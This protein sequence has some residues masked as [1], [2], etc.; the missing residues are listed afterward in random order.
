MPFTVDPVVCPTVQESSAGKVHHEEY[1][2]AHADLTHSIV[3]EL[4][5]LPW[6]PPACAGD[7]SDSARCPERDQAL[8][9]RQQLNQKQVTCVI[10]AFG[11]PGSL[12]APT[13]HWYEPPRLQSDGFPTPVGTSFSVLAL[14]SQL[15]VV[16]R[17]PYV[18]S[19]RPALGEATRIGVPA[20]PVPV[21]CPRANDAP[22]PKLVDAMD[23]EGLGRQPVV[24]ELRK[25]MLPAL[26]SCADGVDFCD[27]LH[28]SG[29]E[30]TIVARRALTCVRT[31][32]D[33]KLSGPAPEVAYSQA[34]GVPAG[35][36]VPPFGD[37][38]HAT[39][40]FGLALTWEEAN[41]VAKHPGVERLWTSP[42]L[43]LGASPPGCPPDYDAPVQPPQCPTT[44]ES[45]EGK[46]TAASRTAWEAATSPT[47]VIIAVRRTG[48]IC[49]RPACPGRA[50]DCPEAQRYND[51]LSK[52]AAASQ[53]CVRALVASIG[54]M[55]TTEAL[56][57]GNTLGATLTWP[58]IQTVAAHPHVGQIEP[59]YFDVPP[60]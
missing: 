20:P 45:A 23:L 39:L 32:L 46:F 3:V 8:K 55:A 4:R 40:A 11:P 54:G 10:E 58:Q 59:R 37:V 18:A 43:T 25:A 17:H 31:W 5:S 60:P 47:E 34:D 50:T 51:R 33:S 44:T 56:P 19:L 41:E 53:T 7:K 38:I 30:R 15:E 6:D 57:L 36:K 1:L 29:W 13:A 42:N 21:E 28:A 52:E 35:P 9:T 14:W 24:I 12:K 27:E 49:P 26:R 2:R 16:A 22:G 48:T